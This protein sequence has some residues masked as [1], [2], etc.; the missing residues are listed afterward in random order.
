[1]SDTVPGTDYNNNRDYFLFNIL[2]TRKFTGTHVYS[3][4]KDQVVN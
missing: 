2:H 4:V 1:M 3:S